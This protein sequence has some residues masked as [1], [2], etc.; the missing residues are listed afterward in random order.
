MS[1]KK[2]ICYGRLSM[3]GEVITIHFGENGYYETKIGRQP[4]TTV[5]EMNKNCGIDKATA[6]AMHLCSMFGNWERFEAI[7]ADIAKRMPGVHIARGVE[8][9]GAQP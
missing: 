3:T 7:R 6:E 2:I 4:Q 8:V 5:D 1:D 9:V